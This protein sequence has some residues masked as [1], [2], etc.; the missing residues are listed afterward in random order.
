MTQKKIYYTTNVRTHVLADA[1]VRVE[2]EIEY[3]SEIMEQRRWAE[4]ERGNEG[5]REG[6]REREREREREEV[7][8]KK[9][10]RQVDGELSPAPSRRISYRLQS[11]RARRFPL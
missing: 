7:R 9:V 6:E 1:D 3:H 8:E 10:E 11:G 5:K 4:R 2:R